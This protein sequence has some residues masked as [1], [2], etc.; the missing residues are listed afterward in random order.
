MRRISELGPLAGVANSLPGA[1]KAT[2]R[3]LLTALLLVGLTPGLSWACACGCGV[4]EV[5]TPSLLPTGSGGM[6]WTEYDFM[7]QYIDWH[8]TQPASGFYNN[9]KKLATNFVTVGGQY[10][11][12]RS[13][14][15]MLEVPYWE[16]NYRGAYSG[17]NDDVHSYDSNSI[18][19]IRIM[20]MWT[21]LQED[22]S[23]G[24][25]GGLKVPSGDWHYPKWDRDTQIGTGSTDL[26]LGV[27]HLGTIPIVRLEDRPFGYYVQGMYDQPFAYQDHYKNGREFDSGYGAYYD[28]GKVGYVTELAPMLT[29][30]VSD[31]ARDRGTNGDA[32]D[33]G[34]FRVQVA[35]GFETAFKSLRFYTDIELPIFRN[36]NGYQLSAPYAIKAILSYSF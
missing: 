9:D 26:L 32:Y 27:Y 28:F 36:M 30:L 17:N 10:M 4:F 3:F 34:Y 29:F 20:G 12:D 8:A 21:G 15:A 5:A 13:W 7:N 1:A 19:D 14:G 22:M 31:R 25:L 6:V 18:G 11:F 35:P 2:R 24:F 33:S 23:T 16:R